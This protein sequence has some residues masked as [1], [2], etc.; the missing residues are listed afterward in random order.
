MSDSRQKFLCPLP[1]PRQAPRQSAKMSHGNRDGPVAS[2]EKCAVVVVAAAAKIELH[3]V[4]IRLHPDCCWVVDALTAFSRT[5]H[6]RTA[7]AV[8]M[9]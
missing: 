7:A 8:V 6:F 2:E 5:G 9:L 3:V 4:H 1:D